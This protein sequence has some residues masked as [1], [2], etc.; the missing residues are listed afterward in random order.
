MSMNTQWRR[1]GELFGR[2]VSRRQL[3]TA[4][5]VGA[6]LAAIPA[7]GHAQAAQT[8]PR[9]L[10]FPTSPEITSGSYTTEA[11]RD[12]LNAVITPH[13]LAATGAT[14]TLKNASA[15]GFTDWQ[16]SMEQAAAAR[17]QYQIDFLTSLGAM[18]LVTTFTFPPGFFQSRALVL[19]TAEGSASLLIGLHMTAAREFAELGEPM[20]AK[21]MYQAGTQV[22][23]QR[24]IFRTI[25][26][27]AGVTTALPPNNKVFSTD[28]FLYTR[29]V[30]PVLTKTGLIGGSG[31]KYDYPGRDAVLQA[32]G[33]MATTIL[34]KV[35]NDA[36]STVAITGPTS[37]TAER[38]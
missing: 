37:L 38:P 15:V 9:T 16:L 5:A 34:Q 1:G 6:A 17:E 2:S 4:A 18:P 36:T 33:P 35:P 21:W 20:L 11:L 31:Q 23:E 19:G 3:L 10:T 24:A 26:A 8:D 27:L 12:I 29:D 30:I 22:A 28:L 25:Q 32:A 14:E 13:Y 7:A